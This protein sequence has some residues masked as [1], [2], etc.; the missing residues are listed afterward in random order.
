MNP[1]VSGYP[2]DVRRASPAANKVGHDRRNYE[3]NTR[4]Q[5]TPATTTAEDD[6]Q[7]GQDLTQ[8]EPRAGA[9]AVMDFGDDAGVGIDGAGAD[10]LLIP[11]ITIL[12]KNSPQCDV[13]GGTAVPGAKP[14]DFFNTA[15]GEIYD[16]KK[17]LVV[18]P[19]HRDHNFAE[20]TP[21]NL[22]GGFVGTHA[23]DDDLVLQLRARYGKF[24]KMF[25]S[26]RKTPEGLP[27]EGTEVQETFYLYVLVEDTDTT[28]V[29]RAILP[30]KSTQIKKYKAWISRVDAIRYMSPDGKPVKPP[31]WAHKWRVTTV[32][33]KNAK[34]SFSGYAVRLFAQNDDGTEK[35]LINS[36]IRRS[37]TLYAQG[38]EFYDLIA[39]GKAQAD[40]S[41]AQ[42]AE[43]D[44]PADDEEIPM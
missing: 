28:L 3:L 36:L 18:V 37:E 12:Q 16:G 8:H 32:G 13:E 6:K 15:T 1:I 24:G 23:P 22:G 21:R 30:F 43:G 20:F 2:Y 42:K 5:T 34:G 31:L 29:Q 4:T 44:K 40:Y 17:G 39:E 10:E 9:L 14:G 25:T 41:G 19:V 7:P 11:F 33:E 38:R 27:A 26:E 35:P